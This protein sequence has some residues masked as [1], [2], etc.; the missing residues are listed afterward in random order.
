MFSKQ[1][2]STHYQKGT[3]RACPGVCRS[4]AGFGGS[5]T[6]TERKTKRGDACLTHDVSVLFCALQP[7][8]IR[9]VLLERSPAQPNTALEENC[10]SIHYCTAG[11]LRETRKCLFL[12]LLKGI[13]RLRRNIV[14]PNVQHFIHNK[15]HV[16][17]R[18]QDVF[19]NTDS[20]LKRTHHKKMYGFISVLRY[21]S[22]ILDYV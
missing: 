1:L 12:I 2:F 21:D 19:G 5:Q 8:W 15:Q 16:R 17:N 18:Q 20:G 9:W 14:I 4:P 22:V 6:E 11:S 10:Y 3:S 7:L 13:L